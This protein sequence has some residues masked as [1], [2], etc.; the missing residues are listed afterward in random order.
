MGEGKDSNGNGTKVHL[1]ERKNHTYSR[2]H[3]IWRQEASGRI[4][5]V[6]CPQLCL[7]VESIRDGSKVHLWQRVTGRNE[8]R[9]IWQADPDGTLVL[10]AKPN[11]CLSAN[12]TQSGVDGGENGIAVHLKERKVDSA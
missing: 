5:L 3:Q 8:D 10:A 2:E 11:L 6:A 1:W 12:L 4:V 7:S 9:Q